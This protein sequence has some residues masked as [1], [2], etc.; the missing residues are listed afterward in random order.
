VERRYW[1]AGIHV[2]SRCYPVKKKL[3]GPQPVKKVA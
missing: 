2:P 3:T 1:A